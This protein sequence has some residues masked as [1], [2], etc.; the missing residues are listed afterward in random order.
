M[1]NNVWTVVYI[2]CGQL[3]LQHILF[4]VFYISRFLYCCWR[5]SHC[6][7]SNGYLKYLLWSDVL[8]L[9]KALLYFYFLKRDC[10]LLKTE[11]SKWQNHSALDGSHRVWAEGIQCSRIEWRECRWNQRSWTHGSLSLDQLK[12]QNSKSPTKPVLAGVLWMVFLP[13]KGAVFLCFQDN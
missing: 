7:H 1:E 9:R 3:T 4:F 13:T 5:S 6:V 2:L 10:I 12:R 11:L 8:D